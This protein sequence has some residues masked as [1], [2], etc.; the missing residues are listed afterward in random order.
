MLHSLAQVR[1]TQKT[2]NVIHI[3]GMARLNAF[4][5]VILV[6]LVSCGCSEKACP[7]QLFANSCSTFRTRPGRDVK[8][9]LL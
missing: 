2:W 5:Y 3:E 8:G 4:R 9:A 6:A 7:L 1:L